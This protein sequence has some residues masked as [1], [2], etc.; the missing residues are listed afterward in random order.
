MENLIWIIA[1]GLAFLIQKLGKDSGVKEG[2]R[3]GIRRE[4]RLTELKVYEC[5]SAELELIS[6]TIKSL[7]STTS[8]KERSNA[9]KAIKSLVK[10]L[11]QRIVAYSM[12]ADLGDIFFEDLTYEEG[13]VEKLHQLTLMSESEV[14]RIYSHRML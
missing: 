10:G 14:D 8:E 7:P 12:F 6:N 3:E 4:E 9:E 2:V 1:I 13:I 11:E 5:I